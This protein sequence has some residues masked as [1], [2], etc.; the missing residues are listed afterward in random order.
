M[1]IYAKRANGSFQI[2]NERAHIPSYELVRLVSQ[3]KVEWLFEE[4]VH[5]KLDLYQ[6]VIDNIRTIEYNPEVDIKSYEPP[7]L[8]KQLS[9]ATE[10]YYADVNNI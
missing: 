6:E 7:K 10:I 2:K 9:E 4:L 5:L 1:K 8:N 3:D